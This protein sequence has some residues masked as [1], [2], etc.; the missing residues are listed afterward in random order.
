MAL[1]KAL[2]GTWLSWLFVS[3]FLIHTE[4]PSC[5]QSQMRTCVSPKD[6]PL[7][8]HY[9]TTLE[10]IQTVA[11]YSIVPGVILLGKILMSS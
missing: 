10:V 3:L 8:E 5:G 7:L 6:D 9:T 2:A 1:P 4:Q 11:Y